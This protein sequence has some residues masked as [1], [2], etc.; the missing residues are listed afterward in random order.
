M[1]GALIPVYEP[2]TK[3]QYPGN[4][5]P[6]NRIDPAGQ[7]LLNFYFLPNFDNRAVSGGKL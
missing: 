3:I 7:K 4:I 6:A 1:G 2:G 5:V